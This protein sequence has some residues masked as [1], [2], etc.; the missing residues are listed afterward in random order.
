MIRPDELWVATM[1]WLEHLG[2][3][4]AVQRYAR[5]LP[6]ELRAGWGAGE[7]Y[8]A[9]QVKAALGRLHLHG[10]YDAVAYAA[11]LTQEEFEAHA[12]EFPQ[13]MAYEDARRMFQRYGRSSWAGYRQDPISDA[14]AA[15]RYG[16]G[17]G[18]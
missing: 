11:Y 6:A 2:L 5:R 10:R 14:Q 17:G 4:M 9:G 15:S 7:Y 16:L 8:T 1:N 12:R 13:A 3:W 18:F